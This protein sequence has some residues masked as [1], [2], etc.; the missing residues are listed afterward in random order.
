M[1]TESLNEPLLENAPTAEDTAE[2]GLDVED[3]G[4]ESTVAS[5]VEASNPSDPVDGEDDESTPSER[6]VKGALAP[7][8]F[9]LLSA[10]M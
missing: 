3:D 2:L 5:D 7:L 4:V 6:G 9:C 10:F 8:L 1:A